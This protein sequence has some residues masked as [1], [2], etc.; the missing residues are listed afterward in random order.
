[1]SLSAQ[2]PASLFIDGQPVEGQGAALPVRY[3]YT[4]EVIA[5]LHEATTD[6]VA[7]ACTA[8]RAAGP[9]WAAL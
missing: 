3:A 1:M 5:T 4:G 2:P 7:A 6:Q 9:A 8:A